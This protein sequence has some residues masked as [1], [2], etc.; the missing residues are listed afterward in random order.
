MA[1]QKE[2]VGVTINLQDYYIIDRGR[3]AELRWFARKNFQT[4]VHEPKVLQAGYVCKNYTGGTQ[5]SVTTIW[6]DIPTVFE[7]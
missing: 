4:G 6:E 7:E 5:T 1:E 2:G 3:I